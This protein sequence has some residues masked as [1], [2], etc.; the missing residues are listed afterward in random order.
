[1][2]KKNRSRLFR[3]AVGLLL[4][5]LTGNVVYPQA[6][7][8]EQKPA[9]GQASASKEERVE[10]LIAIW[11][12]ARYWTKE[13]IDRMPEQS[14]GFKPAPILR[15]F[16]EQLLHLAGGNFGYGAFVFRKA[17]P[18]KRGELDKDEYKTKA[19]LA[20]VVLESYDFVLDGLRAASATTL[21][22]MMTGPG[23]VKLSRGAMLLN[24][25]EHQTHHRGQMT[26]YVRLKGIVPPPEPS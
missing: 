4:G 16:A 24:A 12:R 14:V 20:K 23:G 13:Y 19:A 1:M 21:D 3:L 17:P 18:Y 11:T 5:G 7:V 2:L 9:A 22:E 25:F 26:L 6:P 8:T 10:S 15:S